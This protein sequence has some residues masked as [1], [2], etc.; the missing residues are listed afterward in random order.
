DGSRLWQAE[1]GVPS[2]LNDLS[3]ERVGELMA[4]GWD[5][6]QFHGTGM[7]KA[8]GAE[9]EQQAGGPIQPRDGQWKIA[10]VAQ[11][12]T[13]CAARIARGVKART[14][15]LRTPNGVHQL[16][17]AQPFHPERLLGQGPPVAWERTGVNSWHAIL[18]DSGGGAMSIVVTVDAKVLSP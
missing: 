9:Q 13:S 15:G 16:Q 7:A 1:R 4:S 11:S 18:H 10:M 3:P 2:G 5:A 12:L 14:A 17:F 8:C 6:L